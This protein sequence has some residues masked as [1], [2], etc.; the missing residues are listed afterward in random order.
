MYVLAKKSIQYCFVT[1]CEYLFLFC[2][3]FSEAARM[4]VSEMIQNKLVKW[5]KFQGSAHR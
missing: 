4:A 1:A 5:V 3:A 2:E